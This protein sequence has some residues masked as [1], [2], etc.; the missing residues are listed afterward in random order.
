MTKGKSNMKK[1]E[2]K[3]REEESKKMVPKEDK[4]DKNQKKT[5]KEYAPKAQ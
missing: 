5:R 1:V 2:G 3:K 4:V